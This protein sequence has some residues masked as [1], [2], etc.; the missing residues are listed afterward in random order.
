MKSK[1]K[2]KNILILGGSGFIGSN[3]LRF[4]HGLEQD[5][6]NKRDFLS[7]K[8]QYRIIA[9]SHEQL[10]ILNVNQL[11]NIFKDLFPEIVINFAAH[12]DA[13][14]AELQRGNVDGSV[15]KTN[16]KGVGNISKI[17][18]E[19]GSF[20]IHISTDMVFSGSQNN[21]GPYDEKTKPEIKLENLSWYGWTK[22]E[23]ERVLE[24][25]KKTAIIRVG[26]V[27]N[28]LYDPKLDYV[29]K[30]LYLFDRNKLYSL[31]SDQYLTLTYVPSM[32]EV[33]E[34]LI[35]K[36]INGVFHVASRNVFSP[37]ELAKYLIEKIRG[38]TDVVRKM[39]INDYFKFSPHRYP[40]Y[41]GLLA[42]ET[43]KQ[44]R[45]ELLDWERIV[46]LYIAKMSSSLH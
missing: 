3:F 26:N 25:N 33:M 17:C 31:F 36:K 32:F 15:W 29:G 22:A 40:Q 10:D 23:G 2:V 44:L 19:Y 28:I 11:S 14:S 43:A 42:K 8:L 6:Q 1:S 16:V 4:A 30:I 13:N 38:K 20:F 27:T 37:Y 34:T 39:S 46:D 9:P 7:K 5:N 24:D 45:V 18:Q 41:G 12:R 35:R 21:P